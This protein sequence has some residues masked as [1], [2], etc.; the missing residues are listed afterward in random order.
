[1]HELEER[2][3]FPAQL[4]KLQTRLHFLRCDVD[5][6]SEV[7]SSASSVS[8][9]PE[10]GVI[11]SVIADYASLVSRL[12][13]WERAASELFLQAQDNYRFS[14]SGVFAS[15]TPESMQQEELVEHQLVGSVLTRIVLQVAVNHEICA[16][17]ELRTEFDNIQTMNS[18]ADDLPSGLL[19]REPERLRI[20]DSDRQRSEQ[21]LHQQALQATHLRSILTSL[22]LE[23]ESCSGAFD[24]ASLKAQYDSMACVIATWQAQK[25]ALESQ[26]HTLRT[27]CDARQ[28]EIEQELVATVDAQTASAVASSG[29]KALEL[30]R[31]S[32]HLREAACNFGC[33]A[34]NLCM[35]VEDTVARIVRL[36]DSNNTLLEQVRVA[37]AS[38][39]VMVFVCYDFCLCDTACVLTL[40]VHPV[41]IRNL[42]CAWWSG[43]YSS[44][45]KS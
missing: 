6:S 15:R 34:E 20:S 21:V 40:S 9:I 18:S 26:L 25:E 16:L 2:R 42:G 17:T 3:S 23:E 19:R 12:Q 29:C 10:E 27:A 39:W 36:L 8:L 41:S 11:D 38:F 5:F 43:C 13:D 4:E 30:D 7:F 1:M 44:Q 14:R 32:L 31:Q 22:Q 45:W 24:R 33:K 28:A 35:D 37:C